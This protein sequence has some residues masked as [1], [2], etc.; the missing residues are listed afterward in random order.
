VMRQASIPTRENV[1][2][3]LRAGI[4]APGTIPPGNSGEERQ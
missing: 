2:F 3:V 1:S 4:E